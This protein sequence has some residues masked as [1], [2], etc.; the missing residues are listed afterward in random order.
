MELAAIS[1][2]L[3]LTIRGSVSYFDAF[4]TLWDGESLGA[5]GAGLAVAYIPQILRLPQRS[6]SEE[7]IDIVGELAGRQSCR[8]GHQQQNDQQWFL[9]NRF[10]M[11]GRGPEILSAGWLQHLESPGELVGTA[12]AAAVAVYAFETG[13]GFIFL[14]APAEGC[15]ALSIAAAAIGETDVADHITVKLDF[16]L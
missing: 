15:H 14:H 8:A 10:R 9:H 12:C 11:A 4:Q 3:N 13:D 2:D 6:G 5:P 1:D 7:W 16:Y